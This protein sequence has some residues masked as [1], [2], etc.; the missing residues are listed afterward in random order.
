M[1]EILSQNNRGQELLRKFQFYDKYGVEEY[2]TYDPDEGVLC[3]WI[4]RGNSL[5]EIPSMTGWT[6]PRLGVRFEMQHGELALYGPDGEPFATYAQ[7]HERAEAQAQRAEREQQRA[8]REQ[9]RADREQQRA[10]AERQRA[11]R[12]LAQLKSLGVDPQ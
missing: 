6:S 12:L 5:V 4:R 7:L 2:Y 9:Q 3:G 11:E 8:D 10:E 1:F